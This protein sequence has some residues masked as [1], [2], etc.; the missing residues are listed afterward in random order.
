MTQTQ[1]AERHQA[2]VLGMG[3][4]TGG[5]D[6]LVIEPWFKTQYPL[7]VYLKEGTGGN[8][9]KGD[10]I[11][12]EKG[13]QMKDRQGQFKDP[14]FPSSFYW[15][16]VEPDLFTQPQSQAASGATA[17]APARASTQP[18]GSPATTTQGSVPQGSPPAPAPTLSQAQ[19]PLGLDPTRVS[20]ERQTSLN[21][22]VELWIALMNKSEVVD[23]A[24][25]EQNIIATAAT[26]E[27]YLAVGAPPKDDKEPF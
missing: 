13:S 12:V 1:Q 21:R 6:Y 8:I 27:N 9:K 25:L 26:F 22:A 7:N 18:T 23:Q 4:T 5:S 20:I 11:T 10:I 17:P 16:L 15:N 14:K 2:K 24:N 3:Q 19:P